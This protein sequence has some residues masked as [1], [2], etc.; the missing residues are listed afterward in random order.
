[1]NRVHFQSDRHR[2]ETPHE[3]FRRLDREFSFTLDVSAFPE[4]AKCERYF[5]PV[6]DGLAKEWS[7]VCWM[8][9]L[10][11]LRDRKVDAESLRGFEA[12]LYGCLLGSGQD[13]H[14]MVA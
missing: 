12:W 7:G 10:V 9:P 11:W 3:L 13:R 14:R 6:D 5:T 8:N 2:W 1:M 4:T